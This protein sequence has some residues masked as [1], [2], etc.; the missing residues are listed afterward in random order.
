MV[1]KAG[2]ACEKSFLRGVTSESRA[3]WW[4]AAST[5][6]RLAAHG[7]LTMHAE[8]LQVP[9]L[10]TLTPVP[11]S[12]EREKLTLYARNTISGSPGAAPRPSPSPP[13]QAVAQ[14]PEMS[15]RGVRH[16]PKRALARHA[17]HA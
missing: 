9:S 16:G 17:C 3:E 2:M 6:H 5:R 8:H 4:R 15:A 10:I 13:R 14:G 7:L 11:E 1:R 12:V